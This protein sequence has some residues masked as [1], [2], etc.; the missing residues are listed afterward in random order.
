MRRFIKKQLLEMKTDLNRMFEMFQTAALRGEEEEA[1]RQAGEFQQVFVELGEMIE[2]E[3][4][5]DS[6]IIKCLERIC[7]L[8][9]EVT[10][11]HEKIEIEKRLKK[12]RKLL[13]A[14]ENHLKY[15][16]QDDKLKIVFFPY[17]ASMWTSFE[18]IWK[19][20][21]QDEECD[22][23][24]VPIPYCEYEDWSGELVERYEI[25]KYPPYVP[26]VHYKRYSL[27]AERPD[28]AFIHNPYDDTNTLTSILPDFYSTNIK[29][30][31][32]LLV[33]S[34]YFVFDS[35]IKGYSDAFIIS[36]AIVNSD[37]IIV[38]SEFMKK[39]YEN[40]GYPAEKLIAYGS[41]KIDMAVS[42]SGKGEVPERWKDKLAGKK[43]IFLLNT[44][45][46][47]F[48]NGRMYA[49]TLGYDYAVYFHNEL[50]KAIEER[51]EECG[52]IWRPHPLMFAAMKQRAPECLTYISELK[53]RIENSSFGVVD[54]DGGY[55]DAFSCS[56]A[57]ITTHSTLLTEYL[58]TKKPVM[59]FG[60]MTP[61]EQ[62]EQSPLDTRK[63]YFITQGSIGMSFG[64][65]M[66]MIL[67]GEDPM[68]EERIHMLG[69]R[70]F[71]NMD[72]TAG[73]KIYEELKSNYKFY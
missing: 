30:Y 67:A 25:A 14:Y 36:K 26:L 23:K 17:K 37:K 70:A 4:G 22:A 46:S 21:V 57:L 27:E 39:I 58:A 34:H 29:K 9:Y 7:E 11:V 45:W 71:A 13:I 41:P 3:A 28:I 51:Q 65:F 53:E 43:K 1:G 66:D 15:D 59:I 20:A 12:I 38:Q 2:P 48:M 18:S 54:S 19:C 64:E 56:D 32:D 6:E 33:Y 63:C 73:E 49:P 61:D 72:G 60:D 5:A 52:L 8:L 69:T 24:V 50:M 40:H 42:F 47:Y 62:A 55:A 44:H 16:I 35:Y 10:E 31:A 68:R